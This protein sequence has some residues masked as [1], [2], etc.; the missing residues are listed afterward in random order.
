MTI[1]QALLAGTTTLA[2]LTASSMAQA[3]LAPSPDWTMVMPTG[4]MPGTKMTEAYVKQIGALA[5]VWAY[6]MVNLQ[7][8]LETFRPIKEAAMYGGVLPVGPVN[9]ITMLTDYIEPAQRAVA[10]PN[11][12]VIYGQ[13]VL[14][15]SKEPV[16]VQVP[17]F[18]QRFFVYQVVDQRTDA[19]AEIG[20]M[21]GTR[22]GYYLIAGPDWKGTLP[23]GIAQVFRSPTNIA[24]LIPRVFTE[25]TPEDKAE[26]QK[27]ASF[28]LSYPLSKYDRIPKQRDWTKLPKTPAQA[29]GAE[30]TKWVK[31][32]QFADM[33][34]IV[35][36]GVKPM[37]GEETLHALFK[38][39]T[40]AAAKDPKLKEALKQAAVEADKS[41]ISPLM[42]FRN[43][44]AQLPYNWT[45]VTN[46]AEFGSDYFTRAAAAKAN[47]FINKP[48]ETRYFTQDLDES[49][50][51]LNGKNRY[52]ITLK[53]RG[54]PVAGFWS[55][56]LYDK[57]HFFVPNDIKRYSVGTKNKDLNYEQDGSLT[58]YVQPDPPSDPKQRANWLPAPKDG[59]FSLY[60]RA[61]WPRVS[62]TDGSW[63]PPAVKKL[64]GRAVGGQQ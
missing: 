18:G 42:E 60:I 10:A 4:P 56:T 40:D 12:D 63:A 41:I 45:T 7:A 1:K 44:G 54:P 6:P 64:E 48:N 62:I 58:V 13:A 23:K 43:F 19:F 39:V 24:Y 20:S 32:E 2:L 34:P 22:I 47:I 35:L 9:E 55:L 49:G 31:P 16:V 25:N 14:D 33:L 57:N 8:R 38:S 53:D 30:E 61:Y 17:H 51:R 21:Y 28:I 52:T 26:V 37:P 36:D 11:Q 59:D 29:E 27:L 15:L 3:Q 46:G 5:Y 50:Q